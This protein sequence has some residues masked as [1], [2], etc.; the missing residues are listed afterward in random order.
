M[1]FLEYLAKLPQPVAVPFRQPKYGDRK[2]VLIALVE[3]YERQFPEFDNVGWTF[4]LEDIDIDEVTDQAGN[5]KITVKIIRKA[6]SKALPDKLYIY[7]KQICLSLFKG[8]KVEINQIGITQ[9]ALFKECIASEVRYL[10]KVI[11][12]DMPTNGFDLGV[13]R[14]PCMNLNFSTPIDNLSDKE[15][16]YLADILTRYPDIKHFS[17]EA[18]Y[19]TSGG[20]RI[21][22]SHDVFRVNCVSAKH[23]G[24]QHFE[25]RDF[26]GI[27]SGGFGSVIPSLQ[28][29]RLEND[30]VINSHTSKSRVFKFFNSKQTPDMLGAYQA[31]NQLFEPRTKPVTPSIILFPKVSG[32]QLYEFMGTY[33]PQNYSK[34]FRLLIIYQSLQAVLSLHEK[35]L[36]HRD[37]KPENMMIDLLSILKGHQ[38]INAVDWDFVTKISENDKRFIF[39]PLYI[40]PELNGSRKS[41]TL[42]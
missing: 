15:K 25:V 18:V 40:A 3:E 14:R 7:L 6:S 13:H 26:S 36:L 22:L 39:T 41:K 38:A 9:T 5:K 33:Q 42:F 20:E 1:K 19:A 8:Q 27:G 17:T 16:K 28:T 12:K 30:S 32:I 4:D 35:G 24:Q 10:A 29:F 37:I 34:E 23:A 21:K 31:S 11:L 2:E